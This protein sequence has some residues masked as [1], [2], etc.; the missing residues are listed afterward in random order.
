MADG[1][2]FLCIQF[3]LRPGC[4]VDLRRDIRPGQGFLGMRQSEVGENVAG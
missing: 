4:I 2:W 1:S 3:I